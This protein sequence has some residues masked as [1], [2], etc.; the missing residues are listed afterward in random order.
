DE[1][2]PGQSTSSLMQFK[3]R[4][5]AAKW[6]ILFMATSLVIILLTLFLGSSPNPDSKSSGA[7]TPLPVTKAKLM[8]AQLRSDDF[9]ST[10][11]GLETA[12]EWPKDDAAHEEL[13]AQLLYLLEHK[14][15]PIRI[16]TLRVLRH[17]N[18]DTPELRRSLFHQLTHKNPQVAQEALTHLNRL[19]PKIY[20]SLREVL[21]QKQ[22]AGHFYALKLLDQLS[23]KKPRLLQGYESLLYRLL[24]SADT[25]VC[26]FSAQLIARRQG[27]T[28]TEYAKRGEQRLNANNVKDA[29]S[30]LKLATLIQPDIPQGF[31]NLARAEIKLENFEQALQ[32]LNAAQKLNPKD[33]HS[34]CTSSK[35]HFALGKYNDAID[36][37]S[38]A[39]R[40]DPKH[41]HAYTDRA[42]CYNAL[43]RF[44]D[45]IADMSA[46]IQ[47]EESNDKLY[48]ARGVFHQKAKHWDKVEADF[49]TAIKL[50]SKSSVY[51]KNR[52]F[53]RYYNLKDYKG[54]DRDCFQYSR[55]E[56]KMPGDLLKIWADSAFKTKNYKTAESIYSA[57]IKVKANDTNALM[58][59][60]DMR[61]QLEQWSEASDDYE[62]LISLGHKSHESYEN[63]LRAYLKAKRIKKG[64]LLAKT[65]LRQF[66][67]QKSTLTALISFHI[68]RKS[69]RNAQIVSNRYFQL[70][71]KDPKC[72]ANFARVYRLKKKYPKAMEAVN[73]AIEL[74]RPSP[75]LLI[76]RATIAIELRQYQMAID[77]LTVAIQK[78]PK[79]PRSFKHRAI[80]YLAN[81]QPQL[82]L[83][84]IYVAYSQGLTTREVCTLYALIPKGSQLLIPVVD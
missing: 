64:D 69:A 38:I 15:D 77:D 56:K 47:L 28:A 76:I 4:D 60:A 78:V 71:P 49:S 23:R 13:E 63:A 7:S 36:D 10:L 18:S 26:K 40:I 41:T 31:L 66:P 11:E 33:V 25:R 46:A 32:A 3:P 6:S 57:L 37:L 35:V 72:H 61:S 73:R 29:Q 24:S 62:K 21:E 44:N 82:A 2:I 42:Q 84:D 68:Q 59:R 12:K 48:A 17:R 55:I 5:L 80:A 79:E 50:S 8:F 58:A 43:K 39:L 34:F 65:M 22:F 81:N 74:N 52:A 27:M 54:A 45:A 83:K 30:D 53:N 19:G 14:D 20:G 75:N 16:E 9:K 70:F 51:Y 67:N 1:W